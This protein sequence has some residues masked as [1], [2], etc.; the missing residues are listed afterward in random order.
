[1]QRY[2]TWTQPAIYKVLKDDDAETFPIVLRGGGGRCQSFPRMD[3]SVSPAIKDEL[4]TLSKL[5]EHMLQQITD[6]DVK[7]YVV[8]SFTSSGRTLIFC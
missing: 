8:T 2:G 4:T 5:C 1:M 3:R 6:G 7:Y